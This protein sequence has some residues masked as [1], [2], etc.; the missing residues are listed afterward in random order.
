M[1]VHDFKTILINE[2]SKAL[3]RIQTNRRISKIDMAY[4]TNDAQYLQVTHD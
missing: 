2:L 1:S 3:K 4:F